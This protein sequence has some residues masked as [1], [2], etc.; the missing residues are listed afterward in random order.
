MLTIKHHT[1][2]EIIDLRLVAPPG[3][4]PG[5]L[6]F[7]SSMTTAYTKEPF[8]YRR[9]QGVCSASP[10]PVIHC[11][12]VGTVLSTLDYREDYRLMVRA[13]TELGILE[14]LCDVDALA[15]DP[16]NPAMT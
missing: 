7:Q 14:N 6:G 11:I 1:R 12:T 10:A 4:A 2:I 8:G 16:I 13:L 15:H 9:G 3:V 5:P